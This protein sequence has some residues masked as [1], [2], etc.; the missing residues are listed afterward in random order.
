MQGKDRAQGTNARSADHD[1]Q[2][3]VDTDRLPA[4]AAVLRPAARCE[5]GVTARLPLGQKLALYQGSYAMVV[6]VSDYV[7]SG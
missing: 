5:A 4:G 7:F 2:L 3:H 1:R 6:G